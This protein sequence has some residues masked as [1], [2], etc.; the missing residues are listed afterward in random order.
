MWHIVQDVPGFCTG[1]LDDQRGAGF[2]AADGEGSGAVRH[3]LAVGVAHHG[4]VTGGHKK[5]HVTERASIVGIHLLDQQTALG[6]VAEADVDDL[7]LLAGK[8]HGLGRGVDDVIAVT[9]QLLDDIGAFFQPGR[10]EAAI[11]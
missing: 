2:D 7:L 5:L 3:K 8:V 10:C 11:F 9:G 6:A 4:A 1:F